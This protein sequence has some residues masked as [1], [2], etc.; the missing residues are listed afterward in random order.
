MS[1]VA[2][3]G[4]LACV[5]MD[6]QLTCR[7]SETHGFLACY[8]F[9]IVLQGSLTLLYN[10]RELTLHKGNLF[11]YSPGFEVIVLSVSEDYRGGCLLADEHFTL[12]MSTVRDAIRTAYVS[13][14]ELAVPVL[15]LQT[16]DLGRLHELMKM[17]LHYQ[18]IGLPHANESIRML[19]NLFLIDLSAIHT[20]SIREQQ[21]PKR[22]EEIF[23]GFLALLPQHFIEHHD[24]AFYASELSI[25]T[26]YLSRVVRQVSGGST[27]IDY[28]NKFLLM[29]AVFL[30]RQT[31][32]SVAQ[33]A[34][35]L[36]FAE[37]TTFARFFQR[38][39]GMTPREF[40][41]GL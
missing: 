12:S 37:T 28:I 13:M 1:D 17:M 25:T 21:L 15:S 29:E 2:W 39:K 24:I 38:M 3:D 23:L 35:R 33:I 20:H 10:S 19:Y 26:T 5:E 30:L 11:I 31:S 18:Q 36:H 4:N 9:T 7:I 40:R 22:V 8:A 27:V 41:K 14:V 34:D 32:L 6:A 16:D